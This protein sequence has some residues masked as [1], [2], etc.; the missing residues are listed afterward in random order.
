MRLTLLACAAALGGAGMAAVVACGTDGGVT[1]VVQQI[2]DAGGANEGVEE[3]STTFACGE[4][5]TCNVGVHACCTVGSAHACFPIASGCP[6]ERDA[7]PDADAAPPPAL[8]CN[9]Y[10]NCNNGRPCCYHPDAGSSCMSTCPSGFESLCRR[11][12]DGCGPD[13]DCEELVDA[14]FTNIGRCIDE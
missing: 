2:D 7:G 3:A 1:P 10:N 6:P 12:I 9:T 11:G 14:P 5:N 8:L 4:G 13:L